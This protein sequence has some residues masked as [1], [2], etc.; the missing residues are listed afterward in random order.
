MLVNKIRNFLSTY[1]FQV[2]KILENLKKKDRGVGE[3]LN[4]KVN[5][6]I[7]LEVRHAIRKA[8]MEHN[9]FNISCCLSMVEWSFTAILKAEIR[10]FPLSLLMGLIVDLFRTRNRQVK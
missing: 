7:V 10:A 4:Q 5:F 9:L 3:V 1:T 8:L 6:C 2:N